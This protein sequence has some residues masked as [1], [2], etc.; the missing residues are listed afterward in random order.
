MLVSGTPKY[1][2]SGGVL[3]VSSK[4]FGCL[5]WLVGALLGCSGEPPAKDSSG[6]AITCITHW[7][8]E[9]VH[10]ESQIRTV[11]ACLKAGLCSE[12]VELLATDGA[13]VSYQDFD[14]SAWTAAP[15]EE[16]PGM[17]EVELAYPP[18]V[19]ANLGEDDRPSLRVRDDQGA[20]LLESTSQVPFDVTSAEGET[21]KGVLLNLDGT[22]R[23]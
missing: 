8:G 11:Q 7:K 6:L 19:A 4:N 21:C 15:D 9:V 1:S 17:L 20:S 23:M 10:N 14:F 3:M 18:R 5:I 22:G 13:F 2:Q 12:E 16:M